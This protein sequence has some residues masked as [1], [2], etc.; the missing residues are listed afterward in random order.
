MTR[1]RLSPKHN[2]GRGK[3]INKKYQ[4]AKP[5]GGAIIRKGNPGR[6]KGSLSLASQLRDKL[7]KAALKIKL[8]GTYTARSKLGVKVIRDCLSRSQ[9]IALA[10]NNIPRE[11]R[12][13]ISIKK[14]TFIGI[15]VKKLQTSELSD[16]LANRLSQKGLVEEEV[17]TGV[18]D[19]L[20]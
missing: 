9:I 2:K 6:P 12:N 7:F 15:E 8:D 10:A 5:N 13:K 16:R 4:T 1:N 11:V 19:G 3:G 14:Q 17:E 20:G 18:G